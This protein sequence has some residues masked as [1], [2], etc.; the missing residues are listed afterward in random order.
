MVLK[1]KYRPYDDYIGKEDVFGSE[2][3]DIESED[4]S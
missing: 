3:E 1:E 4:E 2:E